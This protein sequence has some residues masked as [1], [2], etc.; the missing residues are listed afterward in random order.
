MDHGTRPGRCARLVEALFCL[1]FAAPAWAQLGLLD[2]SGFTGLF[3]E[4]IDEPIRLTPRPLDPTPGTERIDGTLQQG[5]LT[6]RYLLIRPI[7]AAPGAP[8]VL[9]LHA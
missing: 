4:P 1:S 8:V 7:E 2:L 9:M 3:G 5:L 6:R